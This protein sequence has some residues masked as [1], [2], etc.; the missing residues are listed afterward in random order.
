MN[1][2]ISIICS[3]RNCLTETAAF[4]S[5]LK[6][7]PPQFLDRVIILDDGSDQE[8]KEFLSKNKTLKILDLGCTHVNY[9]KEANHFADIVDYSKEFQEKNLNFTYVAA[10][11]WNSQKR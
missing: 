9:W 11:V 4:L 5:S 7:H 6:K 2:K 1:F 10:I 8:T 3:V